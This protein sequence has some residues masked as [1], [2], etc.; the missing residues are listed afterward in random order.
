MQVVNQAYNCIKLKHTDSSDLHSTASYNRFD[1]TKTTCISNSPS[2]D[3]EGTA[4]SESEELFL[5]GSLRSLLIVHKI[6]RDRSMKRYLQNTNK[7][8]FQFKGKRLQLNF[9]CLPSSY[10]LWWTIGE[11][12]DEGMKPFGNPGVSLKM[13]SPGN[14]KQSNPILKPSCKAGSNTSQSLNFWR[15]VR[16]HCGEKSTV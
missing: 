14:R 7:Q 15:Q 12:T 8:R 16:I 4:F 11:V 10:N 3:L 5:V 1:N 13:T 9:L 6:T 2:L